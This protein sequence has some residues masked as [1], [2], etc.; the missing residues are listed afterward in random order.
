LTN[1]PRGHKKHA[2]PT[3]EMLIHKFRRHLK[4]YRLTVHILH[5]FFVCFFIFPWLKRESQKERIQ[6]W[7]QKLLAIFNVHT[8]M[9]L[10]NASLGSVIVSNH[11]SWLDIF[12]INSLAPSRF[13]AKSDIRSWPMLGWLAEKGGTIFIARGSKTNLKRIYHYLVEQIEVGE[14][15]AFFPEGGVASQG[16]VLPFHANLFE[17]AIHGKVPVQPIALRYLTLTS[18]LHPAIEFG[19]DTKFITSL[20]SVLNADVIIVEL[21]GLEPIASEN[22]HRRDLA[23]ATQRVVVTALQVENDL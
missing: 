23:T 4:I 19:G 8:K 9:N 21:N 11:I 13:V 15:V 22:M 3:I 20:V 1:Q 12:V 10:T 7:S 6:G 17:A 18:E 16:E 2:H 5:G 14:R